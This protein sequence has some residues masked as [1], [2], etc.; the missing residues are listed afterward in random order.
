MA[1][2]IGERMDVRAVGV[3]DVDPHWSG[4]ARRRIAV[5][6]IR[7]PS[8]DQRGSTKSR[9]VMAGRSPARGAGVEPRAVQP[10]DPQ[11]LLDASRARYRS[12]PSIGWA[13]GTSG[14]SVVGD[15]HGRADTFATSTRR[16]SPSNVVDVEHR[17]SGAQVEL[18]LVRD[19][20]GR[21]DSHV[22]AVC[23]GDPDMDQ[24]RSIRLAIE[25][26]QAPVR[27]RTGDRRLVPVR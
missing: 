8:G 24:T 27:V 16:S 14:A 2:R 19:G 11:A 4:Q 25:R 23:R 12:R 22:R 20:F 15:D 13:D 6:A 1:E 26:D 7:V 9:I 18:G 10:P 17:L 5:N 3:R 21:D